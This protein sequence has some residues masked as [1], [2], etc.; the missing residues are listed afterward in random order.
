MPKRKILVRLA[1]STALVGAAWSGTAPA[2]QAQEPEQAAPSD[3]VPPPLSELEPDP[4]DMPQPEAPPSYASQQDP[5]CG[6]L[7]R[8]LKGRMPATERRKAVETHRT[9]HCPAL[10]SAGSSHA[11]AKHKKAAR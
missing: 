1:L 9:L 4:P 8:L 2:S 5:M 10:A 6:K 11:R 7:E 3:T